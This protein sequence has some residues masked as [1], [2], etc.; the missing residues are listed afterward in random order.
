MDE[1]TTSGLTLSLSLSLC[2]S[3]SVSVCVCVCVCVSVC[4]CACECVRVKCACLEVFAYW[5]TCRRESAT[6]RVLPA[7][8]HKGCC[9]TSCLRPIMFA[10]DASA[11]TKTYLCGI[12]RTDRSLLLARVCSSVSLALARL[13]L[14]VS[15]RETEV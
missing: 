6:R 13:A 7:A 4:V 11:A 10:L 12:A 8:L 3:V 2:V 1:F 5:S 14:H 15:A 9:L